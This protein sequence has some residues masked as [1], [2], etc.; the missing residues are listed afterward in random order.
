MTR[1]I[2][3]V[4]LDMDG[5]LVDTN[6]AHA[7]TWVDALQAHGFA[8][9]LEIVRPLIG[10]GGD[11]LLPRLTGQTQDSELGKAIA[12]NR[13]DRFEKDYL[14]R[15]KPFPRVGE[16]VDRMHDAGLTVLI[17]SSS[18]RDHLEALV[19]KAGLKGRLDGIVSASDVEESKPDPDVIEAALAKLGLPASQAVMIGDTPYDIEAAARV[20]VP[21]IAFRSGGWPDAGLTGAVAVYDD[22]ADLLRQLE[23][24]LLAQ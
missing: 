13:S 22:A 10:L 23:G 15:V 11:K 16:L 4:I 6:E 20:G 17:A 2:R 1:R 7:Q 8:V 14:P 21:T 18:K 9:T 3:G 24:S 5:T 19:D 12:K